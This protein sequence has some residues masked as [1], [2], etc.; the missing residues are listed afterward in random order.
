MGGSNHHLPTTGLPYLYFFVSELRLV[1][2]SNPCEGRLVTLRDGLY[3]QACD[4]NTGDSEARVICRQLGC[5]AANA[6]RVNLQFG[7]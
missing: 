6:R 1:G 4:L 5:R 2:G 7:E 3:G